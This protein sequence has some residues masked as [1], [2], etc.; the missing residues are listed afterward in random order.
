MGQGGWGGILVIVP[1]QKP[2][3]RERWR[4]REETGKKDQGLG[5][6]GTAALEAGKAELLRKALHY[7]NR[8]ATP[9]TRWLADP[10][11][12]PSTH[13]PWGLA[14]FTSTAKSTSTDGGRRGSRGQLTSQFKHH[15][16][17]STEAQQENPTEQSGRK[18]STSH[19]CGVGRDSFSNPAL[20]F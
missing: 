1:D 20:G 17:K 16:G 19:A 7:V 12:R 11:S 5:T 15:L 4:R 9:M 2:I 6:K 8:P 10:P 18:D 13:L 3:Y 14:P